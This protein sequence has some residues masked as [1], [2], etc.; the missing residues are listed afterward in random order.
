MRPC[1]PAR[2]P[3]QSKENTAP[4]PQREVLRDQV[5]VRAAR[6]AGVRH[7]RRQLVRL[8]VRRDREGVGDVPLHP[9]RQ[10][11]EPLQEQ[12][13]VERRQRGAEVA[14]GLGAQ[15]HQVAVGA[16]RLVELQ[17]VVGRRRVGDDGEPAVGPVERA[18]LDHDAADARAVPADELGGGVDHDVGAPLD[19]P[20]QVGRGER[21]VD[22]QRE[23]VLVGD[24]RHGLDVEH[25]ARRVADRL[26]EERLR[27]R[28]DGLPPRVRVVGVD[29]GQLDVHLA[30]QVLELVD[31]AA[32]QRGGGDDVV[33]GLEQREQGGRLGGD[34]AGERDPAGAALEVGHPFLEHR[35]RSGS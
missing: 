30:Q 16:E 19:R 7:V 29:P 34:A 1:P 5:A 32:V 10:R 26:A 20:A 14:Q 13:R 8:E 22:D 17:A 11:L 12:E 9:Q 3:A 27:V 35:D 31:R 24:G 23:L 2:P 33:A 18:G 4:A 15:L 21:V 25:V 28:P 6:Q